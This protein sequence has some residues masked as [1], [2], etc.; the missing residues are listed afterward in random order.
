[1]E[2]EILKIICANQG[3][4]GHQDLI[5]NLCPGDPSRV[6]ELIGSG[7]RL[8]LCTVNGEQR[9]VARS[10][11]FL[12][13]AKDCPGGCRGL[14]LCRGFLLS[15]SCP[16]N[17]RQCSFSHDLSSDHN[18][19]MLRDHGLQGLSRAELC[20]LQLQ[21]DHTLLPQVCHDY[22]NGSGPFG[23]CQDGDG[24]KRLHVCERFISSQCAGAGCPKS[25]DFSDPQPLGVLHE[26]GVPDSLLRPLKSAYANKA[27]LWS[28]D[29]LAGR[30]GH[31]FN[32]RQ[33]AVQM[34]GERGRP[35][36]GAARQ[37]DHREGLLRPPQ[38]L[39]VPGSQVTG[40]RSQVRERTR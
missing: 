18:Q 12:C 35:L 10:R 27:A 40:H 8:V 15:E 24:C 22:N 34:A 21:S 16:F 38:L 23:V 7:D 4:V 2:S 1:M 28:A 6:S 13:R 32:S 39:Q 30:V 37:R 26:R 33:D 19:R 20:T 3:S 29:K 9:V 11:L 14:H 5:Y 36:D 25:H 31:K 17:R